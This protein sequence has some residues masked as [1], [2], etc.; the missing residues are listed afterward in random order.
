[1]QSVPGDPHISSSQPPAVSPDT[2]PHHKLVGAIQEGWDLE[3]NMKIP[4]QV[5]REMCLVPQVQLGVRKAWPP[6]RVT[7]A[8]QQGA[9]PGQFQKL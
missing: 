1:M 2:C 8:S 7:D 5:L 9:E 3:L 4:K 6:T